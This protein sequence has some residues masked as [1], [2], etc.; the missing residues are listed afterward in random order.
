MAW[1]FLLVLLALSF[2]ANLFVGSI[3]IPVADVTD[4]LLGRGEM[5]SAEHYIIL[6]SR[7]PSAI[8]A[9]LC[10]GALAVAGLLMQ[11]AFRNPLAG[12]SIMGV[13]SGASLGVAVVMLLL[14]GTVTAGSV[15]LS[16]EIAVIAGALIGALAVIGVLLAIA[17]FVRNDLLLL[18]VGILVGYLASSFIMILNYGATSEGVQSYV[19]WGMGSFQGVPMS[20]L[21]VMAGLIF[22]G[23]VLAVGLVKPLDTLLLG[24]DYAVSLGVDIRRTK[25]LLLLS[26]GVLAA[27]ATAYCGPVAFIGLAVP[28]IARMVI[29]TDIHR[30][31][32]PMTLLCGCLIALWCNIICQ[33]PYTGVLSAIASPS[34][35]PLNAVTPLFGVPVILY[36]ILKGRARR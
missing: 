22:A 3:D 5:D 17:S 11:T 20:R 23:L 27:T 21:P 14:G 19:M 2:L 4:I 1:P 10:G 30:R 7:L 8:S 24:D 34:P 6:E 12:P 15:E 18:I 36:V 26:T 29:R 13:N 31:L 16:G 25:Q 9:T 32:L 35:L 33:L 28:H